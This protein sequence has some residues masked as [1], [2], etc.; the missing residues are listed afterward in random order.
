MVNP[1][2]K[3]PP[4]QVKEAAEYFAEY[5]KRIGELRFF[6]S[7]MPALV[8]VLVVSGV[9]SDDP[10]PRF[11]EWPPRG[12]NEEAAQDLGARVDEGRQTNA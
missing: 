4:A 12:M 1:P 10:P 9:T 2:A 6:A 3:L 11:P 7:E 8:A 5:E